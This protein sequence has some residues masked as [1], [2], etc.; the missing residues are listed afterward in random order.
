[1]QEATAETHRVLAAQ[2]AFFRP[3]TEQSPQWHAT[4]VGGVED[5]DSL[6]QC[7]GRSACTRPN[8]TTATIAQ[9][10][11]ASLN[12]GI[13]PSPAAEGILGLFQQEHI[14]NRLFWVAYI[15]CNRQFCA[16]DVDAGKQR[17]SGPP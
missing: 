17:V 12:Q 16:P 9:T 2:M 13:I 6:S 8:Q 3:L 10:T 15:I 11:S 1:M 5:T 4:E 7:I 14:C